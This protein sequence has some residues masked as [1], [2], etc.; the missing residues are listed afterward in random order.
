M[1]P[2]WLPAPGVLTYFNKLVWPCQLRLLQPQCWPKI[3]QR[4][5]TLFEI[6]SKHFPESL[7]YWIKFPLQSVAMETD[8]FNG[9][10]RRSV[11]QRC[12]QSLLCSVCINLSKTWLQVE[13]AP[14]WTNVRYQSRKPRGRRDTR[15]SGGLRTLNSTLA[16]AI[17]ALVTAFNL[18][19]CLRMKPLD[20]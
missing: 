20:A 8:P 17:A 5:A 12:L 3:L 9:P 4:V 7:S 14:V 10:D 1:I 18:G 19:Q 6:L 11:S 2:A 16:S 15:A 13:M